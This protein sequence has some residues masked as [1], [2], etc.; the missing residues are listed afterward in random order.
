M[1]GNIKIASLIEMSIGA[2]I[3][4]DNFFWINNSF[5]KTSR[6]NVGFT[7]HF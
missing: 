2:A 6:N 4:A 1:P 7:N 5:F 3:G